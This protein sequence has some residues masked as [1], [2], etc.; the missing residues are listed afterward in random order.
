[1]RIRCTG[2]NEQYFPV[3]VMFGIEYR[4]ACVKPR[5]NTVISQ[6]LSFH[7]ESKEKPKPELRKFLWRATP[8][9]LEVSEIF[10]ILTNVI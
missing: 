7:K 4:S 1:M 8:T 9:L 10:P 5:G 3:F 6:R 2:S